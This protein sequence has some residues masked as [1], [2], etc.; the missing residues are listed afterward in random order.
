MLSMSMIF[1]LR[2][3]YDLELKIV[4]FGNRASVHVFQCVRTCMQLF[5]RVKISYLSKCEIGI[6]S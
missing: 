5:I 6:T 3:G 4:T 1:V 2:K